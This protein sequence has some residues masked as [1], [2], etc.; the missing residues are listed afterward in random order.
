MPIQS[1]NKGGAAKKIKK[2]EI[3]YAYPA[4]ESELSGEGKK[5]N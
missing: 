5:E 1:P 2:I 4:A 3:S